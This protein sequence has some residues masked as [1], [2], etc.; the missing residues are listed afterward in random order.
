MGAG[1]PKQFRELAGR[2][3]LAHT[4]SR[5]DALPSCVKILVA[6][7]ARQIG[8]VLAS[9]PLRVEH[10][11]VPGGAHRQESVLRL[12]EHCD[13]SDD[14]IL[15]HDAARPCVSAAEILSLVSAVA[16]H[17]AAILALPVR[18]TVK[19]VRE[20]VV[21]ATLDRR[22]VWLAQTPQGARREL[23]QRALREARIAGA[24]FTD[25]ASLLESIGIAV[26]VV[27]GSPWNIKITTPH[28][29]LLAEAILKHAGD[30]ARG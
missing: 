12:I 7:D 29:V 18:D 28:D 26:H 25:E 17:G 19:Q 4:L 24:I 5:F 14:I 2:P 9:F 16:A 20:D 1:L 23:L 27:E 6:G 21:T 22:E 30:S 8:D 15:V 13:E 10:H 3:V 11:I